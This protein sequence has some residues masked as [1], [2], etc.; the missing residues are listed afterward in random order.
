MTTHCLRNIGYVLLGTGVSLA[1][2]TVNDLYRRSEIAEKY[3]AIL[4]PH[5]AGT[6]HGGAVSDST[7]TLNQK[8]SVQ[9]PEQDIFELKSM[10]AS[11][12]GGVDAGTT[13]ACALGAVILIGLGMGVS[14]ASRRKSSKDQLAAQ[15]PHPTAGNAAL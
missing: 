13:R 8:H 4:A 11:L 2:I 3:R 12:Q 6:P 5:L 1:L 10:Q 9:I 15:E 7:A 14:A